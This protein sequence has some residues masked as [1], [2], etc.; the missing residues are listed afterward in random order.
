MQIFDG[1]I[2]EFVGNL[3]AGKMLVNLF[4][5]FPPADALLTAFWTLAFGTVIVSVMEEQ[6]SRHA[7][8][9]SLTAW[10]GITL[11]IRKFETAF[12]AH[13]LVLFLSRHHRG[14]FPAANEAG[15]GKFKMHLGPWISVPTK[16]RLH[17]VIFS[18]RDHRI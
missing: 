3:D 12:A 1:P 17:P 4:F 2:L 8:D 16:E 13:D 6:R 15:E 7:L 11:S 14:A 18:F 9:W 10:A 5:K